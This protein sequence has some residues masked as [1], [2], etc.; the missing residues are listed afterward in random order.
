MVSTQAIKGGFELRLGAGENS[1]ARVHSSQVSALLDKMRTSPG[2][3]SAREKFEFR[4]QE[5]GGQAYLQI[6]ERNWAGRL[7]GMLGLSNASQERRAAMDLLAGHYGLQI[8]AGNA[9]AHVDT[10]Q[11]LAFQRQHEAQWTKTAHD[12]SNPYGYDLLPRRTEG[13]VRE[14]LSRSHHDLAKSGRAQADEYEFGPLGAMFDSEVLKSLSRCKA[15][16]EGNRLFL[17]TDGSSDGLSTAG[18]LEIIVDFVE[19]HTGDLRVRDSDQFQHVLD[20]LIRNESF[21]FAGDLTRQIF[22][23]GRDSSGLSASASLTS[24]QTV[25]EARAD[26]FR[27]T[28]EASGSVELGGL[29]LTSNGLTGSLASLSDVAASQSFTLGLQDLVQSDFNV[30]GAAQ[31][32]L[33][34][35]SLNATIQVRERALPSESFVPSVPA[36]QPGAPAV[37]F[38][39][40]FEED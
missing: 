35:D 1:T 37:T 36:G 22:D 14:M 13:N 15:R 3:S 9:D 24:R 26:G 2:Y 32:V 30:A 16:I 29:A 23:H 31:D 19:K 34:R 39:N 12:L 33:V 7:K 27:I 38:F 21:K 40:P 5:R 11:A 18:R 6:K 4:V 8:R 28:Q 20:N 17:H 25:F 10:Q